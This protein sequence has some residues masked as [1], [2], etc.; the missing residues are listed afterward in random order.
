M[1]A[2]DS[3]EILESSRVEEAA[4]LG[5]RRENAPFDKADRGFPLSRKHLL[6]SSDLAA[7][8][9]EALLEAIT[10]AAWIK[11]GDLK[12]VAVNAAF[13]RIVGRPAAE[14]LGS[15]DRELFGQE[16]AAR[17]EKEA[18]ESREGSPASLEEITDADRRNR[19]IAIV[20]RPVRDA[21]GNFAGSVGIAR[22]VTDERELEQRLIQS[23]KM[24]GV[25]RLAGGI[26][27]DFN[28]LLTAIQGY[29]ALLL[30]ELPASDSRRENVEEILKAGERAT[31]LTRQ[32][33]AFSRRQVL[34]PRVLDLNEV[35]RSVARMLSRLIGENIELSTSTAPDLGRVLADP[36]QIEQVILNLAINARDAMPRG[37][38]LTIETVNAR[39]EAGHWGRD[40]PARSGDYILLAVSDTGVGMPPE[41][42][43]HIFEPF[44]TTK[45]RGEGTGLG[46]ATVYG[47]VKQSGGYI[48]AYSEPGSGST[49]K[50]YLPRV[51][52]PLPA[53]EPARPA[54]SSRGSETILLVED[55]KEVRA[56]VEKLLRLQG[57]R[58][59][60]AANPADAI[61]A[62]EGEQGTI[63]LLVTDVVL[64]GLSGR[65]LAA[66]ITKR[67]PG[68]PVL[69]VS[70]YTD[71]AI[72][73]HGVLEPGVHFLQKPFTPA[74]LGKKIREILDG[75]SG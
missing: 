27:H 45:A 9:L 60:S 28:N 30:T 18:Q 35:V 48:W 69:F 67:R 16:R 8:R 47:I 14:V 68:L 7:S 36:G 3:R 49:F 56:L 61:R 15:T 41:I 42:Q 32:L 38:K 50:V 4:P 22:D 65:D 70:G 12:Y 63:H 62:V 51:D 57:Y 26:A 29:G 13:L 52:A 10:D 40:F 54:A 43:A 46:L 58:V 2:H 31:S 71:D 64:P 1:E 5:G 33:L 55:E 17:Y 25:G 73:R 20:R 75:P 66:Q 34:E 24:E 21:A 72:V 6:D 59:I 39:L 53:A 74:Q 19:T 44:F 37:G 11:D 23:Q